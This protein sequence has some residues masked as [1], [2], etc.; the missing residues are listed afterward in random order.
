M[1]KFYCKQPIA[2]CCSCDLL[3]LHDDI[4]NQ[5]RGSVAESTKSFHQGENPAMNLDWQNMFVIAE[6]DTNGGF[7]QE[8]PRR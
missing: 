3:D 5:N 6:V 1:G 2:V 7:Y 8:I 4:L